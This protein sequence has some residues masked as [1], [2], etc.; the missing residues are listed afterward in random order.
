[1]DAAEKVRCGTTTLLTRRP[2]QRRASSVALAAVEFVEFVPSQP[3]EFDAIQQQPSLLRPRFTARPFPGG[4]E[5]SL[6]G[7]SQR[8]GY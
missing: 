7:A 8:P 3:A 1:M 5:S 2:G 4:S 6:N